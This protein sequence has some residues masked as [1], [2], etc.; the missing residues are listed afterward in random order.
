[1]SPEEIKAVGVA[2]SSAIGTYWLAKGVYVIVLAAFWGIPVKEIHK[3][4]EQ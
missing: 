4:D 2:L 1:M 3:G